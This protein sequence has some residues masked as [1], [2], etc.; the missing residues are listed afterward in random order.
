MTTTAGAFLKLLNLLISN[1]KF[2]DRP[3]QHQRMHAV[4]TCHTDGRKI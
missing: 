1:R 3:N 2:S 4:F